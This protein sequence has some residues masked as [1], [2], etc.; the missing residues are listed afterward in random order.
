MF[1]HQY[2]IDTAFSNGVL[3]EEVY[4]Y[5]PFGIQAGLDQAVELNR[6]LFGLKKAAATWSRQ[7]HVFSWKWDFDHVWQTHTSMSSILKDR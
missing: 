2:D 3:E 7:P 4:V 5:P 1:I 6:S